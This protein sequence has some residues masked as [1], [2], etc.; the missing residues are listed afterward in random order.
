MKQSGRRVDAWF[1]F[2]LITT[3]FLSMHMFNE[4]TPLMMDD[5]DYSFSWSTGQPISGV[6]DIIASQA[7][8]YR[9]WGGRSVVHTL[10][11]LFLW[12]GK[13]VFNVCNTLA[14]LLL[15]F[16]ICELASWRSAVGV[17][18][19][20][21]ALFCLVPFYGTVFLW[22]DGSCNYLWGTLLAIMPLFIQ[23]SARKGGFFS[24]NHVACFLAVPLCLIAGWTNENTACAVFAMM[25][26]ACAAD[27]FTARRRV[28]AWEW[29][30]LAAQLAGVLL[31][32]LSPGNFARASSSESG[33][34]LYSMAVAAYCTLRYAGVLI[35]AFL[36][37]ALAAYKLKAKVDWERACIPA[38]CAMLSA[39]ALGVSPQISDRSFTSVIV[40]MLA[41]CLSLAVDLVRSRGIKREMTKARI[42]TRRIA[43]VAAA[44][45]WLT[46]AG[47]LL[48]GVMQ[49]WISWEKQL[50]RIEEAKAAG[51]Q[52]LHGR[53]PTPSPTQ[54]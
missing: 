5:Y 32:L 51:A 16:A 18:L 14:Y 34:L 49:H 50:G 36:L 25:L 29:A 24:S 10:T 8:H 37:L 7:A 19:M 13:P 33:G 40:L 52:R 44:W 45:L 15:L 1:M 3:V 22:L 43:I 26:L 20:N 41:A 39:G 35:A 9:L 11:Q 23:R 54:S 28:P 21:I 6:S 30:A 48:V 31:M 27:T 38:L 12:L 4:Y 47:L 2:V 17:F 46:C 42:R 53:S